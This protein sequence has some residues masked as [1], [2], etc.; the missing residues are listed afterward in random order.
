MNKSEQSFL[1]IDSYVEILQEKAPRNIKMFLI[2]NKTDL[3]G[4]RV[5]TKEQGMKIQKDYGFDLFMETSGK[6]GFNAEELFVEAGKILF[7]E[8]NDLN[9]TSKNTSITE[10]SYTLDDLEKTFN[11]SNRG[12]KSCCKN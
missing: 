6:T 5:I 7:E 3:D 9:T 10:C 11:E 2:G 8:N 12:N 1:D 4:Q